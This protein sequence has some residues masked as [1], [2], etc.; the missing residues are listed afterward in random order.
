MPHKRAKFWILPA[1]GPMKARRLIG[2]ASYGP[3]Q[4]KVL[5]EAFDQ[6]WEAIAA[7]AGDNS[8][9]IE[10]AR[11]RLARIILSLAGERDQDPARLKNA[12]LQLLSAGGR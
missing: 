1:L 4:L 8:A 3:E 2:S 12:A 10:T 6:A 5:F 7:D 11:L 9:A